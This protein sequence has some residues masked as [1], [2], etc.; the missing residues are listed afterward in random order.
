[1]IK[2][3]CKILLET[4]KGLGQIFWQ[5]LKA[6][7]KFLKSLIFGEKFFSKKNMLVFVP[8]LLFCAYETCIIYQEWVL[9][10]NCD[11]LQKEIKQ[12]NIDTKKITEKALNLYKTKYHKMCKNDLKVSLIISLILSGTIMLFCLFSIATCAIRLYKKRKF[13]KKIKLLRL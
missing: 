10:K 6:I 7:G 2:E 5:M 13:K 1:M 4:F 12:G 11:A 9:F 3:L 8:V